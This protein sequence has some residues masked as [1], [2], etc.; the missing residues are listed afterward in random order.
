MNSD[1]INS[2]NI[3]FAKNNFKSFIKINIKK[4]YFNIFRKLK[5]I[6]MLFLLY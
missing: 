5:Y 2:Q 1:K 3:N 6:F 4:L